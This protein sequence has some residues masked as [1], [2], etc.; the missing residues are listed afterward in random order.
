[1]QGSKSATQ[2]GGWTT[3][4]VV[5]ALA[6]CGGPAEEKAVP[7]NKIAKAAAPAPI[8]AEQYVALAAAGNR[9]AIEAARLARERAADAEVGGLAETILADHQRLSARLAEAAGGTQP[10][11]RLRVDAPLSAA[12]Q[13]NL[14]ALRAASGPAFD[15]AYLRQ[16][17]RAHEQ[18]LDVAIRY[19]RSGEVPALQQHAASTIEPISRHLTRART[20]ESEALARPRYEARPPDLP[21]EPKGGGDDGQ[22]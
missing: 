19:V 12:Q 13:A 21:E 14:A 20:L 17:V 10:R 4:A 7:A 1:M 16:Q 15:A 9:Y 11:L 3:L 2:L 6:G 18:A 5:L 8:S 22:R